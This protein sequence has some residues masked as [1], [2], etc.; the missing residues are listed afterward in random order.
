MNQVYKK[1]RTSNIILTFFLLIIAFDVLILF[2]ANINYY[3]TFVKSTNNLLPTFLTLAAFYALAW[4]RGIRMIWVISLTIIVALILAVFS[5]T[6][7]SFSTIHSPTGSVKIMVGHRNVSLGETIHF[8]NFYLYHPIPGVMKKVND[9]PL[10]LLTRGGS[11]DDLEVLGVD[12]AEWVKD[13]KVIFN[14][15][16]SIYTGSAEVDLT[17]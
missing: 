10:Q 13:E 16:A 11:Q 1:R 14:P 2:L 7:N 6:N 17:R 8:Y 9:E 12:N 15:A 5:L 4:D 3:F